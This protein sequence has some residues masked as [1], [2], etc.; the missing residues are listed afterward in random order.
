ME[1]CSC[2]IFC[3]D[4]DSISDGTRTLLHLSKA[5]NRLSFKNIAKTLKEFCQDILRIL[6][7][8]CQVILKLLSSFLSSVKLQLRI[9][10]DTINSKG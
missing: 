6:K 1:R 7:H 8:L 5:G 10:P 9:I 3:I 4:N 2:S